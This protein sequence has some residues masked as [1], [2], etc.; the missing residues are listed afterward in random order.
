MILRIMLAFCLNACCRLPRRVEVPSR[1]W[2]TCSVKERDQISG[3][4][5]QLEDTG[6]SSGSKELCRK[7]AS[8][9]QLNTKICTHRA[10]IQE[11]QQVALQKLWMKGFMEFTEGLEVL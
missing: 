1:A 11:S 9:S 10:E 2:Q 7:L 8:E 6:Q 4:L 5:K 3:R